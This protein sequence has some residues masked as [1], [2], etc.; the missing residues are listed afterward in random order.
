M[1]KALATALREDVR[2]AHNPSAPRAPLEAPLHMTP[3][4]STSLNVTLQPWGWSDTGSVLTWVED[5][6]PKAGLKNRGHRGLKT[7]VGR[8]PWREGRGASETLLVREKETQ[9]PATLTFR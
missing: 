8:E 5:D 2:R 7:L 1:D 9:N 6:L 4:Q 3:R